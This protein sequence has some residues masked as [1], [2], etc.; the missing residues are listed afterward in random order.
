MMPFEKIRVAD[1]TT[2]LAGAGVCTSLSD[3][4]ADVIKVEPLDGDPRR[5][6]AGSFMG[7]NRGKRAIAIDLTKDEGLGIAYKIISI[8]DIMVENAK[9][10]TMDK[11]KLDYKSVKKINP[12]IIYVSA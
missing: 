12:E 4:G 5:M 2:M 11:L 1:F 3:M 9:I 8:S 6:V 10:G 7:T